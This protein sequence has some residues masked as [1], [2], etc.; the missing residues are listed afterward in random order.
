MSLVY[1]MLIDL[2]SFK[3]PKRFS[4]ISVTWLLRP[5]YLSPKLH[6]LQHKVRGTSNK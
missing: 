5:T 2:L 3:K 1:D 6:Q 4:T